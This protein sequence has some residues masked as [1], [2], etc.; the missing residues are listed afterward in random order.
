M[1][2]GL[3]LSRCVK[4]IVM[5]EINPDDVM[6]IVARTSFDFTKSENHDALWL[7]YSYT[8]SDPWYTLDM[9]TTK[10]TIMQLYMD[11]K[12][13][14]PRLYGAHPTRIRISRHWM[15]LIGVWNDEHDTPAVKEAWEHYQNMLALCK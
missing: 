3:S 2:L 1:K 4:D 11:G 9:N 8:S 12:I 5:G 13:F 15:E 6:V 7:H 14:Q 10:D